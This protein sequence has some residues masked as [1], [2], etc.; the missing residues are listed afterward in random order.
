MA[1]GGILEAIGVLIEGIS[2]GGSVGVADGIVKK[3]VYA[4][5]GIVVAGYAANGCIVEE[6]VNT[7]GRVKGAF[8]VTNKCANTEGRVLGPSGVLEKGAE[9]H[10]GVIVAGGVVKQRLMTKS[11]VVEPSGVTEEGFES[12]GG[13]EVS[14]VVI[15]RLETKSGVVDAGGQAEER[16]SPLSRVASRITPVGCW[17]NGSGRR[18]ERKPCEGERDEKQTEPQWRPAN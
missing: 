14:G 3:S 17:S 12:P 2:A 10:P 15:Q 16:I 8:D 13:V 9:S 11:G 4:R 6:S 7:R 18:R 1:D 5:R